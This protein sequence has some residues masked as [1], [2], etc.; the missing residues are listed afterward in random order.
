MPSP[1]DAV[2]ALLPLLSYPTLS[3]TSIAPKFWCSHAPSSSWH[4]AC[5]ACSSHLFAAPATPQ[6]EPLLAP[7]IRISQ[8]KAAIDVQAHGSTPT[9]ESSGH[10]SWAS[11]PQ[12]DWQPELQFGDSPVEVRRNHIAA[13]PTLQSSPV[14]AFSLLSSRPCAL[15]VGHWRNAILLPESTCGPPTATSS[16][17]SWLCPRAPRSLILAPSQPPP[18]VQLLQK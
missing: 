14:D 9:P 3:R 16:I 4:D 12:Y 5:P 13:E 6:D 7:C 8:R 1:D 2:Y 15:A 10:N 17:M 18:S 11:S